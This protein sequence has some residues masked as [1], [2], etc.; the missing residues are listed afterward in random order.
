MDLP[1]SKTQFLEFLPWHS[2]LRVQLQWLQLSAATHWVKDPVLLQ[3]WHSLQL[4]LG[5][6]PW[7]G[8]FHMVQDAAIKTK[9]N[10]KQNSFSAGK[11][12]PAPALE[13]PAVLLVSQKKALA[14]QGQGGFRD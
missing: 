3:L 12:A 9:Q 4:W 5:F 13:N 10:K 8:N 11:G 1:D 2:V 14:D 7:P 6:N